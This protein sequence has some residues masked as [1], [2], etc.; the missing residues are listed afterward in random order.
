MI[1]PR[2]IA[3]FSHACRARSTCD[4]YHATGDWHDILWVPILGGFG[5]LIAVVLFFW[6]LRLAVA[7]KKFFNGTI[8]VLLGISIFIIRIVSRFQCELDLCEPLDAETDKFGA[9]IEDYEKDVY[10]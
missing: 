9:Y 4:I 3:S 8:Y 1:F 7:K 10:E 6:G 5:I 2:I